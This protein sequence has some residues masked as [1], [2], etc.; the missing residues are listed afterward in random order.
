MIYIGFDYVELLGLYLGLIGAV[1]VPG[2]FEFRRRLCLVS[3]PDMEIPFPV[4]KLRRSS[5]N[6]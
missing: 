6:I 2:A 4:G 3:C 5:P 1:C